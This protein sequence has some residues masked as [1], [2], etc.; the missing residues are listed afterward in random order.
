M[1]FYIPLE[2]AFFLLTSARAVGALGGSILS[3]NGETYFES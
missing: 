1:S 3:L 2:T